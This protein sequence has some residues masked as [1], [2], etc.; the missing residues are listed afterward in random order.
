MIFFNFSKK[1]KDI[2]LKKKT[3]KNKNFSIHIFKVKKNL[4]LILV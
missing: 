2:A 3:I 1:R 4:K